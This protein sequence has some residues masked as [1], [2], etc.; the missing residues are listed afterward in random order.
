VWFD[1]LTKRSALVLVPF[2]V[3]A[4]YSFEAIIS[5]SR[6]L[7]EPGLRIP[8]GG[9][10]AALS[11]NPGG[12][13]SLPLWLISPIVL[14]LLVSLF[15]STHARGIA[16]YG[17][18]ALSMAIFFG[19]LSISTRGNEGAAKVWTG[20]VLTIV[21][22]A[23]VAAGTV[24]LDSLRQTLI[25]SHIHYRHFLAAIL[26]FVTATYAFVAVGFSLTTGA[27]SVVKAN[28]ATVMPEFL[29]YAKLITLLTREFSITF[30]E[31]EISH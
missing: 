2:A 10:I 14:V 22:L 3:N 20:P 17:V 19:S 26:I 29:Y 16:E 31:V 4:P 9:A 5:P 1:R 27:N 28:R 13:G 8:G 23:A 11:G 12:I 18:G 7:T 24:L 30:L 6:F 21:T 15:S 25:L